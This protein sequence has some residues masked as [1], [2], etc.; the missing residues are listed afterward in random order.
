M[1]II[2]RETMR[3]NFAVPG[4]DMFGVVFLENQDGEFFPRFNRQLIEQML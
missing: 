1:D 2:D 3:K 4:L